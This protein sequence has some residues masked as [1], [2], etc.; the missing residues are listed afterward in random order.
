MIHCWIQ[1]SFYWSTRVCQ[2]FLQGYY[3]LNYIQLNCK[4]LILNEY[5]SDSDVIYPI[6]RIKEY[7]IILP[8]LLKRCTVRLVTNNQ[9]SI[10]NYLVCVVYKTRLI[11]PSF[12]KRAILYQIL[13]IRTFFDTVFH[14][15]VWVIFFSRFSFIFLIYYFYYQT[16]I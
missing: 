7:R 4:L 14:F 15:N 3:L 2:T 9:L 11:N 1:L 8:I 12:I 6:A 16:L 10:G 13:P 5:F